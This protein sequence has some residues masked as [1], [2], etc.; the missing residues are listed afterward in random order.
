LQGCLRLL[1][2]AGDAPLEPL[3]ELAG[4]NYTALIKAVKRATQRAKELAAG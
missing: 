1:A 2:A 3:R 4:T